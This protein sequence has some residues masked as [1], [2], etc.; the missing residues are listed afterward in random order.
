[1]F[2]YFLTKLRMFLLEFHGLNFITI[3]FMPYPIF[4][5]TFF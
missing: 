3:T 5:L 1:M 2:Q 4:F